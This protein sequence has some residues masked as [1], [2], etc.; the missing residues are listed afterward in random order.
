[1][2]HSNTPLEVQI[3]FLK[4]GSPAYNY[5]IFDSPAPHTYN[6]HNN[7]LLRMECAFLQKKNQNKHWCMHSCFG[8]LFLSTPTK[9]CRQ[10]WDIGKMLD[11]FRPILK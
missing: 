1:M 6:V 5:Y 7:Q 8:E 10:V 2:K 3:P 9:T 11:L 4:G